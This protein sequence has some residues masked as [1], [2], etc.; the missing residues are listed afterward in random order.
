M[1]LVNVHHYKPEDVKSI[2]QNAARI[3]AELDPAP[4]L[5]RSTFEKAVDLLAQHSVIT[6]QPTQ[7]TMPAM[8][9]PGAALTGGRRQ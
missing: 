3:V 6:P 1:Q 5:L 4:E 7:V 8:A 2:L 9:I